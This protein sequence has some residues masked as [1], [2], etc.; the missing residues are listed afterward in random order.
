MASVSQFAGPSGSARPHSDLRMTT[1]RWTPRGPRTW[2][3]FRSSQPP[4]T[5]RLH[6][7]LRVK[8][9]R[10]APQGPTKVATVS[11]FAAPT[12]GEASFSFVCI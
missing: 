10:W 4:G 2:R 12:D 5:A 7:N 9:F 3:Q 8:S 11:Q 6:S 1:V